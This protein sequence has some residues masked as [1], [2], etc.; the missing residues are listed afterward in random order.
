MFSEVTFSL[1]NSM[2]CFLI[3][4]FWKVGYSFLPCPSPGEMPAARN[5]K[6]PQFKQP[7]SVPAPHAAASFFAANSVFLKERRPS[8]PL[9]P[10]SLLGLDG[11]RSHCTS[12]LSRPHPL[13]LPLQH[14]RPGLQHFLSL[15]FPSQ[16]PSHWLTSS[17]C[18]ANIILSPNT[19][20]SL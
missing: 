15:S 18:F 6:P 12:T 8:R 1:R 2:V 16:S 20:S 17:T 11:S 19:S 4:K 3:E 13:T 10:H 14:L 7:C 9:P 5:Q